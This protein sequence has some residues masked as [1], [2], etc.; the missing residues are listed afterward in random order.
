LADDAAQAFVVGVVVTPDDVPADHA[1]LLLVAGVIGAIER[2]IPQGRG[3]RFDP[4]NKDELAGV[5]AISTLLA[6]A[7]ARP[8]RLWPCS[9]AG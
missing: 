2:E 1:G 4:V 3:L 9:G 7:H 6:A 8:G 5:Q